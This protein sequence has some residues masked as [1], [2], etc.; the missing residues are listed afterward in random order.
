MDAGDGEIEIEEN[1]L[2]A[3]ENMS[4]NEMLSLA[5]FFLEHS[6]PNKSDYANKYIELVAQIR[7]D[8]N[9][10]R[11]VEAENEKETMAGANNNNE[12]FDNELVKETYIKA[13]KAFR[14][15]QSRKENIKPYYIF[16]D[17][18]MLNLIEIMP[19][20][21]EELLKISGFGPVKVE[22]YGE[23]VLSILRNPNDLI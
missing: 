4:N 22:K 20:N 19:G 16:N 11:V 5:Q 21:K 12:N 9:R 3:R 6:Q 2:N 10:I 14:L 18:Q 13:L 8:K 1:D 7:E 15:E 23:Q 17:A